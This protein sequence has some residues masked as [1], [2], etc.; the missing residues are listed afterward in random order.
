ML[1]NGNVCGKRK[2]RLVVKGIWRARV[3][4]GWVAILSRMIIV[5]VSF[6]KRLERVKNLAV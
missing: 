4:V 6:E 5:K 1:E 3:K 2:S